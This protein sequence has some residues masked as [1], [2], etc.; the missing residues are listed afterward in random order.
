MPSPSMINHKSEKK[1]DFKIRNSIKTVGLNRRQFMRGLGL[2]PVSGAL[3]YGYGREVPSHPSFAGT[4]ERNFQFKTQNQ[5]LSI[6]IIGF[7]FRGEQ[8]ARAMKHAHPDWISEMSKARKEDP[9]NKILEDFYNQA[10]L[11]IKI[12]GISD[13]FDVRIERGMIVGGI[14]TKGFRDYRELLARKDIDAVIIATPDHWHARMTMD[15]VNAGKHVYLEKC[16]TRTVDEAVALK[17]AIQHK[18]IVFQLGHQGRQGDL[19]QRARELYKKEILGKV[20]LVETTTNRNNPFG[21]WVWPIH[22]K[23]SEKTIDWEMFQG[24][25]APIISYDPARFFRWRCWWAYG[26]GMAGD[27]LTHDYDA[28][29]HIMNLGI[30]HSAIASGGIYFYKDGREVPDV[31]HVNYEYPGRDLTLI[32]SGTLANGVPRGTLIMGHD[33]TLELGQSLT[34]WADSQSTVYKSRIESGIIDPASPMIRFRPPDQVTVDAITSATSKYFADRGLTYTYR[35]GRRVDTTNLHLAEWLNC[36]RHGG[37]TS[38]NI[39]Q[40]FQEAITAH[41]ATISYREGRKVVWDAEKERI[42]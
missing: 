34:I 19:Q 3:G 18:N 11:N 31:F 4:S 36:I 13:V 23:A 21:A 25:D 42:I 30:P 26:T 6:G 12:T 14:D 22:E 28:V 7:G 9:R 2:L 29:N 37:E 41:M 35:E 5:T 16:M 27:L 17:R 1:S 8:L 10:E 39:E 33:A 15:A 24:P 20:T 38:C 40:G 32:Y